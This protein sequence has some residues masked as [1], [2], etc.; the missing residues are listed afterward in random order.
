[1]TSLGVQLQRS[2]LRARFRRWGIE[3]VNRVLLRLDRVDEPLAMFGATIDAPGVL[4]GPMV[5]HNADPDYRN[6]HIGANV[7]LG[8]LVILD[9]AAPLT[10]G[11]EATVSMGATILT[12]SDVGDRPLRERMPAIVKPTRIGAG[13]YVGANVT[14]LPGCDVGERAVVGAGAVVASPVPPEAVVAGVPAVPL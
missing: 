11:R 7:H 6:L 4:H 1:M 3:S 14:I 9:L 2:L 8:R 13:A 12:H 5:V 10:I